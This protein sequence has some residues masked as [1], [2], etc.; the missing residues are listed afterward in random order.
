[1]QMD[2]I[3]LGTDALVIGL[4]SNMGDMIVWVWMLWFADA[5]GS[6]PCRIPDSSLG[7]LQRPAHV[8]QNL[9]KAYN[10]IM[11]L[12]IQASALKQPKGP[13]SIPVSMLCSI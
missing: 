10:G 9:Y 1:M 3:G 13:F 8:M 7:K 4:L 2:N 6:G 5:L 11:L 12:L